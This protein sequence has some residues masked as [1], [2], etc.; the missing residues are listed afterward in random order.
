[1]GAKQPISL[2]VRG[3]E[4]TVM[5]APHA[6]SC[7][8]RVVWWIYVQVITNASDLGTDYGCIDA[9]KAVTSGVAKTAPFGV[10][11]RCVRVS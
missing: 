2:D 3:Q 11:L 6:P 5:P 8:V 1:M 7:R 9:E 10:G 4:K